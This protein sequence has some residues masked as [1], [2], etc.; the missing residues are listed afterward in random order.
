MATFV[1]IGSGTLPAACASRLHERGHAVLAVAAADA[2]LRSWASQ[3]AVPAV[4]LDRLTTS[5]STPPDFLLSIVNLTLLTPA[6]LDWPTHLALNYHDGPLPRYAGLNATQWALLHGES[7]HGVCWHAIT[8]QIDAGD[9]YARRTVP[10]GPAETAL[11]LNAACYAAALAAFDDLLSAIETDTLAPQPQ[12]LSQRTYFAA[13]QRPNR[14][15]SFRQSAQ[16]VHQLMRALDTGPYPNPLGWPLVG[17][18]NGDWV[19]VRH[20]QPVPAPPQTPPGMVLA[21]TPHGL[22]VACA[23]QALELT[24]WTT[25]SGAPL[26]PDARFPAPGEVWPDLPD[27]PV[28]TALQASARHDPFWRQA[29]HGLEPSA[30]PQASTP[31]AAEPPLTVIQHVPLPD[32]YRLEEALTIFLVWLARLTEQI[33]VH[34]GLDKGPAPPLHARLAPL[35]LTFD[36]DQP[37]AAASAQVQAALAAQRHRPPPALDLAARYPNLPSIGTWPV[38]L[39]LQPTPPA[40][41][42]TA[43]HVSANA[44]GWVWYANQTLF[45]PEMLSAMAASAQALAQTAP[46]AP[47]LAQAS[48]LDPAMPAQWAAWNATTTPYPKQSVGE[49]IAAQARQHPERLAVQTADHAVTYGDLL[50]QAETL[51]AALR[52]LSVG[53]DQRVAVQMERTPA[54]VAALL[55]VWLSGG[56]YVPLDP[57]FPADRLN[58]MLSDSGAGALFTD[59]NDVA[60][61]PFMP[62]DTWPGVRL[63]H[64]PQAP[65]PNAPPPADPLAYVLY[66]SGSTGK[67]KGVAVTQANLSNFLHSMRHAPGLAPNDVLAAVT[68]LSFDIAGL[69]LWLTLLVGARLELVS[70]A[71]AGD[72]AALARVLTERGITVMQATPATW[73]LLLEADWPG[74][75]GFRA[76]CG[77]EALPRDLARALLPRVAEL[78]NL[79]GPTETTIWSTLER[80]TSA[81]SPITIGRPIANT[82]LHIFD[83]R[84]Q[85]VPVGVPGE[86]CIGGAG[87]ARGYLNRPELTTE[88]FFALPDGT[89]AYRTGDLARWLPDGRVDFLG[90]RD[91]Q[92]KIRGFR[93]ELDE[94]SAALATHPAVTQAV[95][96]AQ[97]DTLAAYVVTRVAVPTADL[98]A[99][100]RTRLPEYMLPAHWVFLPELPLTPNGKI[101][102]KALP[103]PLAA[104]RAAPRP[105]HTTQEKA[106]ATIWREVLNVSHVGLDDDFFALGGHSLSAARVLGRIRRELNANVELPTLFAAPTLAALAQALAQAQPVHPSAH[107]P[108]S[109]AESVPATPQQTSL[110]LMHHLVPDETAYT[111]ALALDIRGPLA[112]AQLQAALNALWQRHDSLRLTLPDHDGQPELRLHPAS[113]WPLAVLPA[114]TDTQS[115]VFTPFDLATGPLARATLVQHTSRHHTLRLVMHHTIT[116]G[117]SLERLLTELAA[118]YAGVALPPAPAYRAYARA[119]QQANFSAALAY[120]QQ[121]LRQLPPPL[122]LP[123]DAP[124]PPTPVLKGARHAFTVPPHLA[125]TARALAAAQKATPF[126]LALAALAVLLQR[127]TGQTDLLIGVP[128]HNRPT[129]ELE[130]LVGLLMNPVVIRVDM[131]GN[132]TLADVLTRVRAATQAALAHAAAPLEQVVEACQPR[133]EPGINPVFQVMLAWQNPL[134]QPSW[135][136]LTTQARLLDTHTAKLDLTLTVEDGPAGWQGALDYRADLFTQERMERLS[137]HWLT[138]LAA[139]VHQPEMAVAHA[140]MLTPAEAEQLRAWNTPPAR[141]LTLLGILG[142]VEDWAARTPHAPALVDALGSLTYAELNAHAN[143]VAHFLLGHG[144]PPEAVVGLCAER[145]LEMVVLML[146]VWKAGAAYLPLSADLPTERLAHML[147]DSGARLVLAQSHLRANLPATAPVID[148]GA[149][150]AELAAQ[151]THNP[152]IPFAPE[153]LAYVLFTSG[154]T[155][156]PKGVGVE[157]RHLSAYVQGVRDRLRLNPAA[158]YATVSTFAADLGLTVIYP[159]LVSGGE[160]RV[161]DAETA[162]DPDALAVL[163][164]AS[165]VDCLKIVPSH[166]AALL[167]AAHPADLLPRQCLVLGGEA[168]DW[169]LVR[170]LRA[171]A[172]TLRVLN[173]Y[174]PTETTVGVVT[175]ETPFDLT[176]LEG[177]VP[178]GHALPYTQLHVLDAQRQPVPVGV[179]GELYIS[180]AQVSRGY[181]HRPELTAERFIT[182]E[183]LPVRAYRTGDWV[184]RRTDGALEFLGRIDQQ[185][186]IRGYRVELAEIEAV[187]AQ[188]PNVQAAAVLARA[189]IPDAPKQ[190]VAYVVPQTAPLD[191]AGLRAEL[192]TR[193]PDYMQPA[194]LVVLPALPLTANG[195][196]DRAALPEPTFDRPAISGAPQTALE[197][198]LAGLWRAVLRVP[199]VSRDDNFFELG[200]D[201]ILGIQLIARAHRAGLQLLPRHIFQHQ[202]LAELAQAAQA[203]SPAL[204]APPAETLSAPLTPIQHWFFSWP[205]PAPHHWNMPATL[206]ARFPLD[207]HLTRRALM[208]LL[209]QHGMWRARFHLQADGTWQQELAS[210]QADNLLVFEWV[211]VSALEPAAQAHTLAHWGEA[212]QVRLN[213]STGPLVAA[214]LLVSANHATL[215]IVVHHLVM[216]GVSWRI[217]RDDFEQVYSQLA[218]GEPAAL[219]TPTTPFT[220][221]A[222]RLHRYAHS[223]ELAAETTYWHALAAHAPRQRQDWGLEAATRTHQQHFNALETAQVL[224]AGRAWHINSVLLA[225]LAEALHDWD[226]QPDHLIDMEGHGREDV[227]DDVHLSRTVGWFTTHYPVWV[228]AGAHTLADTH[229][230]LRGVPQRGLGYGVLRYLAGDPRLNTPDPAIAFNYLG[231]FEALPATQMTLSLD[232][233]GPSRNAFSP[234]HHRLEINAQVVAGELQVAWLFAAPH[235]NAARVAQL[236]QRF[237]QHVL[238]LAH[239]LPAGGQPLTALQRHMADMEQDGVYQPQIIWTVHGPLNESRLRHAWSQVLQHHAALRL[240]L[241]PPAQQQVWPQ[242]NLRWRF[243]EARHQPQLVAALAQAE[244]RTPLD[245]ASPPLFRLMLIQVDQDIHHLVWTSHHALKDGW[246]SGVVWADVWTAYAGQP[247]KPAP[248]WLTEMRPWPEPPLAAPRRLLLPPGD[249]MTSLSAAATQQVYAKARQ[250]RLTVATLAL[251]ALQKALRAVGRIASLGWV[252]AQRPAQIMGIERLVGPLIALHPVVLP[253][254][255]SPEN[256][257]TWQAAPP[258]VP[259]PHFA[260]DVVL[261][262]QTYPQTEPALAAS[263]LRVTEQTW[264]DHWAYPLNVVLAPGEKLTVRATFDPAH[265]P[266]PRVAALLGAMRQALLAGPST[267]I[268]A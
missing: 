5:L 90:R 214:M 245:L 208:L 253:D 62:V 265:W 158:R 222:E 170:R 193:L 24:G 104:P 44:A 72:G 267:E 78:W 232:V 220:V 238:T 205:R 216:D 80:I 219:P 120:W 186:K 172:P 36:L 137:G 115:D 60:P 136:G 3:S 4:N 77:G 113:T 99:H 174:G 81:D 249:M 166:L 173:H 182:L 73:R 27:E 106:L 71:T 169:A 108:A 200:G 207:P 82:I 234:R 179:P 252:V 221:W 133:R 63:W 9:I 148:L 85:P 196:I 176:G 33:T 134:P 187:L 61:A 229:A 165:P 155:G 156:R 54:L 25:L 147:A 8:R 256:L 227:L 125:E 244:A 254:H 223:P 210:P 188:T 204:S 149:A 132:P 22:V 228:R 161:V 260:P 190:L 226:G 225:A 241:L 41:P 18:P 224:A 160:L 138:L 191:M 21:R 20:S 19:S 146:G 94:I 177:V 35:S 145:S 144:L 122:Q 118:L 65:P 181:M 28:Y 258:L 233:P 150:W 32:T 246:S 40:S 212:L 17:L 162:A 142:L 263:G 67:P 153:H 93:I 262:V 68:T 74:A 29:W 175:F 101:D 11:T 47:S 141:H 100:V 121:H 34:V 151:P 189:P 239:H 242:V 13:H 243:V 185:V 64:N 107:A 164:R 105:P 198:T 1:I 235:D 163:F 157:H 184:R 31:Q 199:Q 201:S 215:L 55:G 38:T 135:P 46:S 264:V 26:T 203:A 202:T 178:I 127:Y 218:K 257:Q 14:R 206:Q 130:P 110:W 240:G 48:L 180:G 230:M 75:P 261:R 57:A 195:K 43:L 259:P 69:E 6:V 126:M 16:A 10:I 42:D 192:R 103:A 247:L 56:A 128:W 124:R 154:S 76:L 52:A 79:Y 7:T 2:P 250:Q 266:S 117:A 92:V 140:P 53:P 231:Q 194:T 159:A 66:T 139:F 102:R 50:A 58:F 59:P 197:E 111:L 255:L 119:Q 87:V 152:A 217:V 168:L 109:P 23:D 213:L 98:L 95:V 45:T 88:K 89:P 84:G 83:K 91:F 96:T 39:S 248:Q 37:L 251:A 211:D 129:P 51:A 15:L 112:V 12:D 114:A 237:A 171:L 116:D 268:L 236:A 167:T 49:Q 86:L 209:E 123:A 183:P 143:Q 70:R 97:S 131:T 30:L